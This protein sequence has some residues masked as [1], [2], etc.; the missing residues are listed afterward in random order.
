M[1]QWHLRQNVKAPSV[2]QNRISVSS[3]DNPNFV[4]RVKFIKGYK[5]HP[6]GRCW[7]FPNTNGTLEKI[8]KVFEGETICYRPCFID[9]KDSLAHN[10]RT[11]I[12]T[13]VSAKSLGKITSP[14]N[15]IKLVT[16]GGE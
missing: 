3:S 11:E 12:Y 2:G 13:H 4:Q 1:S 16:G 8:L 7:S 15:I 10:K 6:E 14:L 5:Y 9:A